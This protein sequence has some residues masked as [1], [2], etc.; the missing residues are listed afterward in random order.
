VARKNPARPT[1][2]NTAVM[3]V[4]YVPLRDIDLDRLRDRLAANVAGS[5]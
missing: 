5:P 2:S 4:H 1:R 3:P